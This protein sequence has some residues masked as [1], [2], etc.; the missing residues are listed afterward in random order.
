MRIEAYDFGTIR[1]DG[2]TYTRDLKIIGGKVIADWWRMEGHCIFIPDIEDVLE[3]KP[4]VLVV[5][6]GA[7]G[8]MTVSEEAASRLAELGIELVVKPTRDACDAFN[9]LSS[10]RDTAFAA[11]LTC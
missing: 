8:L 10:S 2:K 4:D 1:I 9:C 5:G 6:T 11:H 3:A 7:P